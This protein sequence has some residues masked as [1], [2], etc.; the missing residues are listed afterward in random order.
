MNR[1]E[2]T[3]EFRLYIIDAHFFIKIGRYFY[4]YS[5]ISRVAVFNQ[6]NS[7]VRSVRK[8]KE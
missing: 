2:V 4:F 6:P 3:G 7:I 8:S 1:Y 5:G